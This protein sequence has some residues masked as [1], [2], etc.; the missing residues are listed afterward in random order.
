MEQQREGIRTFANFPTMF[1]AMV[2]EH[3]NL[4][5]LDGTLKFIDYR[6]HIVA[7]R[8]DPT[9]YQDYIGEA[10]EPWSYLKSPYYKPLGYPEGIYRVGPAARTN[11]C[12]GCGTTMADQEWADFRGL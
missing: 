3:D 9:K 2:N 12:S 11:V 10:V 4:E 5:H 8:V 1:M 7:P 6:G